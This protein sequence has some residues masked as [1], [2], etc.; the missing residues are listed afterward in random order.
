MTSLTHESKYYATSRSVGVCNI[1]IHLGLGVGLRGK[2]GNLSI[3][4]KKNNFPTNLIFVIETM[5][6]NILKYFAI[7]YNWTNSD[8]GFSLNN[9]PKGAKNRPGLFPRYPASFYHI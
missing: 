1:Y 3:Q 8:T 4:V 9:R 5:G 7:L 2:L 6:K